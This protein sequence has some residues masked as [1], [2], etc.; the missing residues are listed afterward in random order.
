MSMKDS[1]PEKWEYREHTRVKH[2]L[3]EKYLA[4]W[5]PILGKYNPRICYL[6]GFAGRGEYRDGTLGSPLI[7]LKVADGLSKYY[8]E[9]VCI[10]I[11]KDGENFRNLETVLDREKTNIKNWG[12][13]KIIKENDEFS[14]VIEAIFHNLEKEEGILVPSFFFVDP[15]GFGG[16]PFSIVEKILSN[17]KTEVFF[18]FMVR[19]IAR[20]TG[21]PEIEYTFNSLFG[22][23]KLKRILSSSKKPEIALIDLYRWPDPRK[24]YHCELEGIR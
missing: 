6:D 16:I 1:S 23:D 14:N 15:F 3:L 18:T 9:L 17:P 5:I 12:K 20:F 22:T 2:I 21:L 4:A 8:G 10:F 13:I 24:L 7:A 19:D 11:E